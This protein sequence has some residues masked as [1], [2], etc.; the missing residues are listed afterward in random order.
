M[1]LK[2]PSEVLVPTEHCNALEARRVGHASE[3]K[4]EREV[5]RDP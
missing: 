4:R 5:M 2:T 1:G 3:E